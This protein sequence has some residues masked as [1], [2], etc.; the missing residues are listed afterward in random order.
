MPM[1]IT[2]LRV[3]K[4][5]IVAAITK[6]MALSILCALVGA[7]VSGCSTARQYEQAQNEL[8]QQSQLIVQQAELREAVE[9][10]NAALKRENS[11][12]RS[13]IEEQTKTIN[14]LA[15][16]LALNDYYVE[17]QQSEVDKMQASWKTMQA[18]LFSSLQQG[19]TLLDSQAESIFFYKSNVVVT[20]IFLWQNKDGNSHIGRGGF[21]LNPDA[22]FR[23]TSS[24]MLGTRSLSAAEMASLGNE[25]SQTSSNREQ[26]RREASQIPSR[27]EE[28]KSWIS[29]ETKNKA[30]QT[31][32]TVLG[33]FLLHSIVSGNSEQ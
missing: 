25:N 16:Y 17:N 20:A 32:L 14:T 10:E 5:N 12:I 1:N 6:S 19:G 18:D 9:K 2:T 3:I 29:D 24:T 30:V 11:V 31:G 28:P 22:D 21:T 23:L 26:M 8:Q 7:I 27:P 33:T 4:V 15:H 13:K